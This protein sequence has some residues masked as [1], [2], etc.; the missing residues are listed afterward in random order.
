MPAKASPTPRKRMA[1]TRI[2]CF[3]GYFRLI[4]ALKRMMYIGDMFC[5][6]AAFPA[7]VNLLAHMKRTPCRK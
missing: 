7:V 1:Q 6:T 4:S 3:V 2:S 5:R